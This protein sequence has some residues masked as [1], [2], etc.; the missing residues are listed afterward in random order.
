MVE[1]K[2]VDYT[3]GDPFGEKGE[4]HTARMLGDGSY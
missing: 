3:V 2:G 1:I 4:C